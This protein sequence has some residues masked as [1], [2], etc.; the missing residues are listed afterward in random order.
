MSRVLY[1]DLDETLIFSEELPGGAI[2]II[3]RPEAPEFLQTLASYGDV[4][5]MSFGTR[6]HVKNAMREL[7]RRA[8]NAVA[9]IR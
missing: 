2:S 7:G 3:V 5:I 4:W 8:R 9:G 1:S 6:P